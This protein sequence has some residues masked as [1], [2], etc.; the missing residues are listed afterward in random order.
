MGGAVLA[1]AFAMN[2]VWE[3]TQMFVF[4]GMSRISFHSVAGCSAAAVGDA[5][6][7]LVLYWAGCINTRDRAWVCRVTLLRLSAILAIGFVSAVVIERTALFADFWQYAES[8][9]RIPTLEVGLWPVLQLMIVPPS[10]FWVV[11]HLRKRDEPSAR[12]GSP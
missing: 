12:S 6:F 1:A 3:M 2:L 4:A 10:V 11:C 5:L 7:V 9:P 8:M